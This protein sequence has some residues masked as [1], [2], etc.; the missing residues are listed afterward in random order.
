MSCHMIS[1]HQI[2]CTA[3]GQKRAAIGPPQQLQYF[4]AY[5]SGGPMTHRN[6]PVLAAFSLDIAA[7]D[8]PAAIAQLFCGV[9]QR[10]ANDPP[11]QTCLSGIKLRYSSRSLTS[12][13]MY[14][15]LRR[16]GSPQQTFKF[17]S[18]FSS[19]HLKIKQ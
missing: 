3:A 11:Q 2:S 10:R 1:L 12:R 15:F 19:S 13:N 5:Y 18:I 9:L 4:A 7:G 14:S 17:P 16:V 8:C 6:R